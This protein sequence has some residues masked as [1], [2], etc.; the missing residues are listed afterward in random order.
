MERGLSARA[1]PMS[2]GGIDCTKAMSTQVEKALAKVRRATSVDAGDDALDIL[3][4][5]A[6]HRTDEIIS[7]YYSRPK[8]A[9]ILV[10]CLRAVHSPEVTEVYKDA[11]GSK[12]WNV[13]WAAIEGLKASR[14]PALTPLFIRSLRDRSDLVRTVAVAWVSAHGDETAI[15]PL[16]HLLSLPSF[17]RNSPGLVKDVEKA[18]ERLGG[19]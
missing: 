19:K 2:H 4:S 8:D 17:R 12:E 1:K 14:D 3:A 7:L 15:A 9:F 6:K 13:R 11:I 18:L 5:L 10:W 16:K